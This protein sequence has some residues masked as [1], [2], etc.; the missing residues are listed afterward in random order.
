MMKYFFKLAKKILYKTQVVQENETP[1]H[2]ILTNSCCSISATILLF[3]RF[4]RSELNCDIKEI[5][6]IDLTFVYSI[7]ETL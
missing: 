7:M 5:V 1:G 6:I 2:F 3:R 4:V